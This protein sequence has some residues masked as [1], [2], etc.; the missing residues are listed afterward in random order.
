MSENICSKIK[1]PRCQSDSGLQIIY[2]L[3]TTDLFLR[4]KQ[5]KLFLGGRPFG[6]NNRHCSDCGH[7]WTDSRTDLIVTE[8]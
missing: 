7:D 2:G 6:K 8:F 4:A 3:P 5:G 1:C